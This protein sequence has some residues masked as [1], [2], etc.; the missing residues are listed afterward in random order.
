MSTRRCSECRKL[1]LPGLGHNARRHS[2]YVLSLEGQASLAAVSS[3]TAA[4]QLA[5][6]QQARNAALAERAE[7]ATSVTTRRRD[8]Q[9]PRN[10]YL[11]HGD[12]VRRGFTANW[13]PD[14]SAPAWQRVATPVEAL[15]TRPQF[16]ESELG[17]RV[18]NSS[19]RILEKARSH[20]PGMDFTKEGHCFHAMFSPAVLAAL[21][22][23]LNAN[24]SHA[25]ERLVT[26][27]EFCKWICMFFLRCVVPGNHEGVVHHVSGANQA[28]ARNL[29]TADRY[30]VIARHFALQARNGPKA[31]AVRL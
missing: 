3:S 19:R 25:S 8:P 31:E 18:R 30:R 11:R 10:I 12:R 6:A 1:G 26:V 7:Q 16:L 17:A 15:I 24:L 9:C 20:A 23:K 27:H 5:A 13:R 2:Q 4:D 21:H 29:L 22:L 14:P 28:A